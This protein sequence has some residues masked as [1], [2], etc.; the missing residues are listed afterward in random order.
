M[1]FSPFSKHLRRNLTD[2]ERAL[3]TTLRNRQ[4]TNHKFRRQVTL[5]NYVADFVCMEKRLIVEV[6]GGQHMDSEKDAERTAW[7]ESQGYCVLRFWND[8]VLKNK[9]GVVQVIMENLKKR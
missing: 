5:G 3:W 7:L 2:A 1:D 6:D 4:I 9:E 8:E